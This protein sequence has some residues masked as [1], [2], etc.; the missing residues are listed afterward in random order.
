[1]DIVKDDGAPSARRASNQDGRS[2]STFKTT[3]EERIVILG[4]APLRGE[5]AVSGSKNSSLPI[6]AASLLASRG[7]S[8]LHNVPDITDVGTMCEM[9]EAL[10]ATVRR[11][12]GAVVVDAQQLNNHSAPEEL[13]RTMRAS[14]YVAAPL[15]ARLRLAEVPLPGGCVLGPRPINYHIDAFT[16]MGASI[17]VEQGAMKAVAPQWKGAHIYLEPKNSSVGATVNVMMAACLAE[18][19][20]TIENAAREPEVVNLAEFL[21][22]MGGRIGGAGTSTI[23]IEGVRELHGAEH[24]IYNDR[25]EG[26]TFLAAAG[27]SGGDVTITGL[28]PS[29]LP[30]YL[31]KLAEAGLKISSGADWVRAEYSGP[32]QATDIT[33]APFPGFAT[34]LQP[35]VLT[36]MCRAQGRTV[37]RENLYEGRFNYTPEL[38]RMGADIDLTESMAIVNGVARLSGAAVQATDLRAGAALVLAGLCAE[39]RTEVA[40]IEYI[41]RGY[42][43]FVGKLRSLG[44]Q[45]VRQ[46]VTPRKSV[47][48]PFAPKLPIAARG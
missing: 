8:V 13:V 16:K 20:T 10:G 1:M 12:G 22:K 14:F 36:M 41:D 26:G 23:I 9:L 6:L 32:L 29:H 4:G 5:I 38:I 37:L 3:D 28:A 27:V 45:V 24:T 42:E 25:I 33:T 15:L 43:D 31:D 35:P 44:G 40:N 30:V 39:G 7:A 19:T 48:K 34:D 46:Y 47:E 11:E 21:N 18:G 17:T 2:I